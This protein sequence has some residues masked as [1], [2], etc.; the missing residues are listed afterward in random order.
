MSDKTH[1]STPR[2]T[3]PDR[4][5]DRGS[6]EKRRS[7]LLAGLCVG[8]IGGGIAGLSEATVRLWPEREL[9]TFQL[10]AEVLSFSLITHVAAWTSICTI[11][12]AIGRLVALFVTRLPAWVSPWPLSVAA[13]LVSAGVV[14]VW[15][16]AALY[17][18]A[19]FRGTLGL[20]TAA[21]AWVILLAP[22]AWLGTRIGR[23][24]LGRFAI[25]G[26]RV[27]VWPAMVLLIIS[28]GIQWSA[29]GQV[30]SAEGFWPP[31]KSTFPLNQPVKV[32][33]PN[34][35]LVVFDALR[36]DRLGC[37]GYGRKTT[38]HLD[39]FAADAALF[40]RAISPGVWTE[41][42]H[43][44]IFTGL[45][46]SQH[47]VGWNRV[48]LDDRFTT[49]AEAL[50]DVGYQTI[51]L[52]NNPHVSPKTNITQ[53][54]DRFY[55][56]T[57]LSYATGSSLFLFLR[58]VWPNGAALGPVLGRWFVR[59]NGGRATAILAGEHLRRRD[60]SRP[61]FLFVNFMESHG[62]FE[63][64]RAYRQV[65]VK[66]E[67]LA[68]SYE[69]DQSADAIYQH[70][71]LRKPLFSSRDLQIYS[72]LYDARVRELDDCFADLMRE[73]TAEANLD[74]TVI[75][76]TADHGENLGDHD[77]IGHNLCIYNTL[78]H[79]PLI[80]RWPRVLRPGRIEGVVQSHDIFPTVSEWAGVAPEQ[81]GKV[82]ARSL[83]S[84]QRRA[85]SGRDHRKAYSEYLFPPT[86]ALKMAQECDPTFD[87]SPWMV[88]FRAVF[89]RH[90]KL[91]LRSDRR[92][93][94]Y[95]W[96]EDPAEERNL[97]ET[98]RGEFSRLFRQVEMWRRSFK[99]FDPNQ[100]TG[101]AGRRM[102]KERTQRL[103]NLG[104]VQ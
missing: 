93:E 77:L 65:F 39:A 83:S 96:R 29:R 80:I 52:S 51:A 36:V 81:S 40:E 18:I 11:C 14:A 16:A 73:L 57:A 88:A 53:G 10:W 90:Y 97:A 71:L 87:P 15:F 78:V 63:S 25:V 58:S 26:A 100:F 6:G 35:V 86:P 3:D 98:R 62:P 45:Y 48:W 60:R 70:N 2:S 22:T 41:P 101:P 20:M 31:A 82:M 4:G 102:D 46:R 99:P 23:T 54:F 43:A 91:I 30:Q 17:Q 1:A 47:G 8:L 79:V 94:L 34:V 69:I 85:S 37:Y 66:P 19:R 32:S 42:S 72:D 92:N 56:P 5:S 44:S 61:F 76:L 28:V 55:E 50:R 7:W 89:D 75:I 84:A 103:R 59:D 13:L 49:L 64:K 27:A 24:W 67:D 68:R 33:R 21:A 74:D 38:P 104:Y 12:G 95:D 9:M